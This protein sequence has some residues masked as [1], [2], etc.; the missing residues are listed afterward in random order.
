MYHHSMSTYSY[1]A[2]SAKPL[3]SPYPSAIVERASVK[4]SSTKEALLA[5]RQKKMKKAVFIL[6]KSSKDQR[7]YYRYIGMKT[8]AG[9]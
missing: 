8:S 5:T 4:A 7:I 9:T 3:P 1:L 2:A 6:Q